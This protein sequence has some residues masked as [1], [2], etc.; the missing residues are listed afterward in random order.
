MELL[1]CTRPISKD[2]KVRLS[3]FYKTAE[4]LK[5]KLNKNFK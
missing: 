5:Q 1:M 2:L 4:C 3:Q